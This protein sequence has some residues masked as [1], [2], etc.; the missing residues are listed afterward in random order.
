MCPGRMLGQYRLR[1]WQ[2]TE[3]GN[4]AR[5]HR[6]MGSRGQVALGKVHELDALFVCGFPATR[7]G[8]APDK[9]QFIF[10]QNTRGLGL[11]K[12]LD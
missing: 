5:H 2:A 7:G 11:Q 1:A 9:P 6:P 12:P 8:W 10:L 4:E 3:A